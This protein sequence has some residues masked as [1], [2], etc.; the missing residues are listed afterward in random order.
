MDLSTR[1]ADALPTKANYIK[2]LA[3]MSLLTV[4]DLLSYYPRR[5]ADFSE[6]SDP[7]GVIVGQD[8]T[9]A[10]ELAQLRTVRTKFG[11]TLI[12]AK[13]VGQSGS[14]IELIWFSGA[15]VARQ[16][17][18]GDELVVTGRV[19]MQGSRHQLA[20]TSFEK[21]S[22][23]MLHA[24]RLVPVYRQHGKLITSRWLREKIWPLLDLTQKLVDP[25]P[26]EIL[27]RQDLAPLGMSVRAIHFPESED[28]W[29]HARQRLAFDELF[30]LQLGALRRKLDWQMRTAD[31]AM[32]ISTDGAILKEFYDILPFQFTRAQTVSANEI[33]A[34]LA[35]TTP[36]NRLLEGDVGSGKTVVAALAIFLTIRSSSPLG[37]EAGSGD[38]IS[39]P[40]PNP[41]PEGRG[42]TR[43][44]ALLAPTEILAAQHFK[45]FL[46]ILH[47]LGVRAELLTGSTTAKN[48][49]EIAGKLAAGELDLIV[50]TH[51]ILE[52]KIQFKNLALAVIDEQHRFGVEQRNVL[53]KEGTPHVLAM[54]ATPIPRTLALTIFG[55]QDVS[56]IDELPPGRQEIITRIVPA[57]KRLESYRWIE[58]EVAKGRQV[59]IVVPLVEESEALEIKSAK[60]EYARLRDE[61]FPTL[62]V[63]LLHGKMKPKEKEATMAAFAAG[64]IHVLVATTVIEV[65]ID[66]PNATIMLI[67]AADRFG[68]AQLHQLRGRV[69]RGQHQSYCFL[70]ADTESETAIERLG[71]MEQYGDGFKLAEIDLQMRGPGEVFGTRQAGIP[72]FKLAR[73]SDIDLIKRSRDEAERL[74]IAD[75]H[76]K[77]HDAIAGKL[78]ELELQHEEA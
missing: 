78:T 27:E 65:G 24:G 70:F 44:A 7:S 13:L 53:K 69:G 54:T 48:K 50:G 42:E 61:V 47:P 34:D 29:E 58:S 66:V 33:L 77:K 76:L 15:W 32:A 62:S 17:K 74:L 3:E 71:A 36:M 73:F 1:L 19:R 11:K 49:K 63:G 68:L 46:K 5:H 64:E 9:V 60:A 25:L 23:D 16:L 57:K 30:F 59:Y 2:A 12:T 72:D 40:S 20:V 52:S 51:A 14:V 43:Q 6:V 41:S 26:T 35:K 55:D 45:N 56:I 21:M 37:R 22:A 38:D 4:D 75:P 10:G 31:S 18:N 8:C 39:S 67:E 28:D